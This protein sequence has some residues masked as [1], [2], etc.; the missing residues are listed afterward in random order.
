MRGDMTDFRSDL[1]RVNN[2][3]SALNEHPLQ[4]VPP[5]ANLPNGF[6]TTLV[7]SAT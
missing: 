5:T 4:P 2:R 1:A 6:A 7:N 3:A